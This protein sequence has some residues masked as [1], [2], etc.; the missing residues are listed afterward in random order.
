MRC[1]SV[2]L[3]II[4]L[5]ILLCFQFLAQIL[6]LLVH[7]FAEV[8]VVCVLGAHLIFDLCSNF[9]L[10]ALS[11]EVVDTLLELSE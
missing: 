1:Q 9:A 4:G 11:I 7:I 5:F 10:F 2:I 8:P 3:V 6:H